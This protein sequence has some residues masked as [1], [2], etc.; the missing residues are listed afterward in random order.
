MAEKPQDKVEIRDWLGLVSNRGPFTGKPGAA[1]VLKNL[2][3]VSP[4]QL[5]V[6][7]GMRAVK[8]ES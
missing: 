6:R 1:K 7:G 4:G 8:F 3:V 2:R 5:E